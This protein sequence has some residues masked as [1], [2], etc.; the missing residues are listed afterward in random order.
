VFYGL[1]TG[2]FMGIALFFYYFLQTWNY[3][4]G[5]IIIISNCI[6]LKKLW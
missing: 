5:S 2:L 6:V 1:G 4:C 3:I